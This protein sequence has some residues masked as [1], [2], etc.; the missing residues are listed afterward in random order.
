[1]RNRGFYTLLLA[2]LAVPITAW[3]GQDSSAKGAK[4][5]T[6]IAP[7]AGPLENWALLD[8]IKTGL[9]PR[10]PMQLSLD[11]QPEFVRQLVRVQWRVGDPIDLWIIRPKTEGKVPVVLYLYSYPGDPDQFRDDAWCKRTT[12]GGFAAV[13]F[14]SALTGDRYH[15]RPMKQWFVSEFPESLGSTVHD[16]QL[17]LN[18]LAIRPEFDVEH[19]GMFGMGSGATIAVL[20]AQAD[21]RIKTLDLLD[22]WGDWPAWL[23]DSPAIPENERAKYTTQEFLKSVA[24]FDPVAYLPHLK[25]RSIRLQQT[26]TDPIT[27]KAAQEQIARSSRDPKEVV[28]YANPGEHLKAWKTDGLSGWI[29]QQL[30]AQAQDETHDDHRASL[31]PNS[32]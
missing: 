31:S 8:D 24:P 6:K 14:V 22:P 29:K 3:P 2:F 18:Y 4:T 30:R 20:A 21:P 25:T 28:K 11:E 13:G 9:Q 23:R 1:M 19:V 27:P 7:A 15:L 17:I 16:V 26:L 10:V 12:A 32:Q 5:D